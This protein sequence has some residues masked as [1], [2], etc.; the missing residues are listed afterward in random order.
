MHRDRLPGRRSALLLVGIGPLLLAAGCGGGAA[1]AADTEAT[2]R[3]RILASAYPEPSRT[4]TTEPE[5]TPVPPSQRWTQAPEMTI[6]PEKTYFATFKTDKGD[7][8]VELFAGQAPITVNNFV[9]LAR[10]GYYDDTTFHRVLADFMAQGGD[11]TG[12]GSGGPGYA[13]PDEIDPTLTFDDAGYLAMANAGANTN[14]SQFFITFKPT[15]WL[16]GKHT[17]FGK[18]VEGMDVALSL[19]LRDPQTRPTFPG[20]TLNTV[21]IEEQ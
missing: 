8:R 17:I 2:Q 18:V 7:I 6:D 4:A 1:P 3:A 9:F 11:P 5:E 16:N 21:E 14:G 20:E 13:F 15:P 10:E 12:S 19:K